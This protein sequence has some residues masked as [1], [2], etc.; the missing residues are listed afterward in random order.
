MNESLPRR[1]I[2]VV[3]T[4]RSDFGLLTPLIEALRRDA[5]ISVSLYVSGMHHS[6]RHGGT[7][8][9]IREC[10]F[11]DIVVEIPS[12]PID[13]SAGAAGLAMSGVLAGFSDAFSKSSPDILVVMGDRID[14]IPAVLA[15][16][17]H[18]IPVAHIS[19]GELS[20]MALDDSVRHAVTKMSHLHF[21]SHPQFARRVRQ[22]GEEDWRIVIS[23]EPGLDQVMDEACV[24]KEEIYAELSLKIDEPATLFTYHP[25]TLGTQEPSEQMK[26]ILDVAKNIESQIVF[27]YPNN[28]PGSDQIIEAIEEFCKSNS[29]CQVH[30]SLGRRRYLKLLRHTDCV[31]GNSSSGLVEAATFCVPVVNVGDRQK[32]R[33]APKNVIHSGVDR[34]CL[35]DA[36][37]R[38]LSKEF[39]D[40]L[41]GLENPYGDGHASQRILKKLKSVLLGEKFLIKTFYDC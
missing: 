28:D 26:V 22:M 23:G 8:D 33:L 39:R 25:E 21:V 40:E 32:G 29:N 36:W 37:Q 13:D 14:M 1:H 41:I 6:V 30:M 12:V 3:T 35:T 4:S 5:G 16:L 27:T 9:E 18:R 15:A 17:P 31:V 34:K 2:G 7:I 11:D 24:S 19:G 38:A 10:G 20:E